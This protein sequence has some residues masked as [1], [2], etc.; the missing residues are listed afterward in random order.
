M[1]QLSKELQKYRNEDSGALDLEVEIHQS[2]RLRN[3]PPVQSMLRSPE[4]ASLYAR[5]S[6]N[7]H[8]EKYRASDFIMLYTCAC[9]KLQWCIGEKLLEA[10]KM[11]A[12]SYHIMKQLQ[13]IIRQHTL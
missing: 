1:F 12:D 3:L 11:C 2:C 13:D 8:R 9:D 10:N 4:I 5:A 6:Q 7:I